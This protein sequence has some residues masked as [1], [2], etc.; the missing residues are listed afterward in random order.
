MIYEDK[1][2]KEYQ[3]SYCIRGVIRIDKIAVFSGYHD[4]VGR[5]RAESGY[6][7]EKRY[8]QH[9][10]FVINIKR[11]ECFNVKDNNLLDQSFI[12][13]TE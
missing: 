7:Q 10:Q 4:H 6:E 12:R 11:R 8:L 9:M 1:N 3:K 13:Q 5:Q 2:T